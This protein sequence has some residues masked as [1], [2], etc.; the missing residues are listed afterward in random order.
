MGRLLRGND[1]GTCE[2]IIAGS[3]ETKEEVSRQSFAPGVVGFWDAWVHF[4]TAHA[5]TPKR[6][7]TVTHQF[8][9]TAQLSINPPE[10]P[11]FTPAAVKLAPGGEVNVDFHVTPDGP[12]EVVFTVPKD[13]LI[14]VSPTL[15]TTDADGKKEIKVRDL[16]GKVRGP[17]TVK[18]TISPQS[19]CTGASVTGTFTVD[20][21]GG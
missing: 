20:V 17:L 15:V 21:V 6:T 10:A 18:A 9:A 2:V 19:P 7:R 8:I 14:A 1:F 13:S 16:S 4:L 12:Y 3:F 5:H 11:I